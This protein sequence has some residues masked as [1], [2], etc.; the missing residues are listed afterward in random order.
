MSLPCSF[1][2]FCLVATAFITQGVSSSPVLA[3]VYY[4]AKCPDSRDFVV[5][6]L[7]PAVL[8]DPELVRPVLIPF[9][10]ATVT[11]TSSGYE[12]SCQHGPTECL[13]N[14]L[15]ACGIA[16]AESRTLQVSYAACMMSNYTDVESASEKCAGELGLPF[17]TIS[18]CANGQAGNELL[19]AYG[20]VTSDLSP[21]LTFVPT[22][23]LNG[24]R[25]NQTAVLGD[26][27]EQVVETSLITKS[28][29]RRSGGTDGGY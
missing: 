6:Q 15:H 19:R 8:R 1:A 29:S 23:T 26:F 17:P 3:T 27:W 28:E 4:E 10:K 22:V 2:A 7:L 5:Q 13:G 11:T 21:A 14:K 25:G 9:G 12:F 16:L 24:L 20:N 18:D